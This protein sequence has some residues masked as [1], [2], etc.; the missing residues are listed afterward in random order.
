MKLDFFEKPGCKNNRKQAQLL[1]NAGV[2]LNRRDILTHPWSAAELLPF[3]YRMAV[4]DWINRS[5]PRIKKGEI[6]LEGLQPKEALELLLEDPLLIRRPLLRQGEKHLVGFEPERVEALFGIPFGALLSE[7]EL[8]PE[9]FAR[10]YTLC[11][12]RDPCP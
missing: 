3:F 4:P 12:E 5:A 9:R 2:E 7:E 8:R 10:D 11:Q 6:D 1:I